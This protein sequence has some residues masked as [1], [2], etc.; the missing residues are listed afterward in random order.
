MNFKKIITAAENRE[1]WAQRKIVDSYSSYLF[2]IAKRYSDSIE[3]AQDILQDALVLIINNIQQFKS[4][5]NMFKPWMKRI[6][7]NTALGKKRKKSYTHET[8][9]G[10]MMS[11]V[12]QEPKAVQKLKVNDILALLQ[13]LPELQKQVFN[14]YIIDGFKHTEIAGML[15]I[16]ESTSRT[17][18]TRARKKMQSLILEQNKIRIDESLR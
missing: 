6:C 3:D 7:I 8:Y 12:V 16:G 14:L 11:D 9:P 15:D 18:L 2:L 1:P 13:Y 5:E 17:I 4:G 10:E